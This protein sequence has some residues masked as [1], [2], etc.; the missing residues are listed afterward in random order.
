M[1]SHHELIKDLTDKLEEW[2]YKLDRLEHRARDL[3]KDL[4]TEVEAK[5]EKLKSYR[6]KLEDAEQ[7]LRND[8]DKAV[9]EVEASIED[10][11]D[12]VKLL[13]EEI[14]LDVKVDVS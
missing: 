11:W 6:A 8:T 14:E 9:H 10:V 12:T 5:L 7:A 3:P 2:D 13:F 1:A 4:R